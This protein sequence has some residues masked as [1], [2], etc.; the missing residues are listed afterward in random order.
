VGRLVETAEEIEGF[1]QGFLVSDTLTATTSLATGYDFL[2]D[3]AAAISRTFGS[4]G[5]SNQILISDSWSATDL[6]QHWPDI[7]PD[8][9]SVNAHFDHWRAYPA[10]EATEFYNSEITG[11]VG[12]LSGTLGLSMGCHSGLNVPDGDVTGAPETTPDFPQALAQRGGYWV[13]NTGYGYGMDDSIEATEMLMLM[14]SQELGRNQ[15]V[16]VGLA[17]L[18]AKHRYVGSLPSGG[19]SVYHEKAL[20]ESTFYGLPMMRVSVPTPHF[21]PRSAVGEQGQSFSIGE[22]IY[23][24]NILAGIT[25]TVQADLEPHVTLSGTY[26]SVDGE[27]HGAP[28]RPLQPRTSAIIT[29]PTTHAAGHGVLLLEGQYIDIH[30]F[31]PRI[32]RPVTDV[33]LPEPF[34]GASGWFPARPWFL[35]RFGGTDR[36]VTVLGQYHGLPED[37]TAQRIFKMSQWSEGIE[38]LYTSLDLLVFYSMDEEDFM[39]PVIWDVMTYQ[40][41]SAGDQTYL[42]RVFFEAVVSDESGVHRVLITFSLGDGRWQTVDMHR[43][44]GT[45]HWFGSIPTPPGPLHF[46]VQ[47]VDGVGNVAID[48]NKGLF[49]EGPQSYVYLPIVLRDYGGD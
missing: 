31:D 7:A 34:F 4:Y 39:P 6:Q 5:L 1:V 10:D 46:F 24:D 36:L 25:A 40:G 23:F 49:F 41:S 3:S 16:P 37:G 48:G 22:P 13:G 14:F 38:R 47:A 18:R 28:G 44:P 11:A 21:T 12:D 29:G 20:Q 19:M 2:M 45:S 15:S 43:L 8:L 27:V 26:Y 30:P 42:D 33:T 17:F 32:T 9:V 35:N